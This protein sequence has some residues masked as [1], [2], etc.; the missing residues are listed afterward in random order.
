MKPGRSPFMQTGRGIPSALMQTNTS[1]NEKLVSS[2][3]T[4]EKGL[5]GTRP[6]TFTTTTND[7]K[8]PGSNNVSSGEKMSNADW[9]KF[10]KEN[11]NW[12]QDSNRSDSNKSFKPDLEKALDLPKP[13]PTTFGNELTSQPIKPIPIRVTPEE[14]PKKTYGKYYREHVAGSFTESGY[15]D[16]N[17]TSGA[18]SLDAKQRKNDWDKSEIE[19]DLSHNRN[20]K[21]SSQNTFDTYDISEDE[22]RISNYFGNNQ[23]SPYDVAWK[24]S[25]YIKNKGTGEERRQAYIQNSLAY[26]NKKEG[27]KKVRTDAK[28]QSEA[29]AKAKAEAFKNKQLENKQK[30]M[31]NKAK[32][33]APKQMKPKGSAA[34]MK[35]C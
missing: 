7:Y 8:T 6:G 11:P 25:P 2:K 3:T 27:E 17:T 28:A 16:P 9:T 24:D 5:L 33:A 30:I 21:N 23:V 18:K 35:K 4:A 26:I 20:L 14:A 29:N 1:T 12:N 34:K 10:V 31:E 15:L 32:N 13:A 19:G 22:D